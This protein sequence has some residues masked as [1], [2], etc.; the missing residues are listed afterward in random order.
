MRHVGKP[1]VLLMH[2]SKILGND[3]SVRRIYYSVAVAISKLEVHNILEV[4]E[5]N[6]VT[7]QSGAGCEVNDVVAPGRV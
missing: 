5:E 2:H 3:S 6:P 4:H 7:F 1:V